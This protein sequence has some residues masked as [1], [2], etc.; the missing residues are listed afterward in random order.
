MI[1]ENNSSVRVREIDGILIILV[2]ALLHGLIYVYLVP[3]WQHYDEPNHFEY[4]WLVANRNKLPQ[5]NDYDPALTFSVLESMYANDFYKGLDYQPELGT[6]QDQRPVPGVSQL[7]G[8]PLYYGMASIPLKLILNR[9]VTTQMYFVRLISVSIL[10]LTILIAWGMVREFTPAGHP[11]RYLTPLILAML[12]GYVDVMSSINNDVGAVLFMSLSL[13]GSVRL[14][15]KGISLLNLLLAF[16]A[17]VLGFY[18]KSTAVIAFLILPVAL[19]FSLF[20]NRLRGFAWILVFSG[21]TLIILTTIT[22]DDALKWYRST[23]QS[24]PTRLATEKAVLGEY[25]IQLDASQE[26][27]PEWMNPLIQPIPIET[28]EK[29][30]GENATLGFWMWADKP[31]SMKSPVFNTGN[32]QYFELIQISDQP[33][34]FAYHTTFSDTSPRIW[35]GIDFPDSLQG[36]KNTVYVD[37][38]VLTEG[39]YPIDQPPSYAN[40]DGTT[41]SWAGKSFTNYIENGSAEIS[42]FRIIPILDGLGSDFLGDNTRPSFVLA[43]LID[44]KSTWFLYRLTIVRL[45]RTFLAKFG[46]G[47]VYIIGLHPYRNLGIFSLFLFAGIL[48]GLIRK[49]RG[50]PWEVVFLLL[51]TTAFTV[52]AV[53]VRSAIY[54]SVSHIFLPV[55]RYLYPIIIPIA[56]GMGFGWLEISGWMIR[57]TSEIIK[58]I[59]NGK[60]SIMHSFNKRKAEFQIGVLFILFIA[61][62]VYSIYSIVSFYS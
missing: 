9:D 43:S 50:I 8:K 20:R 41:G 19:I 11:L 12:P 45:F 24:E 57:I 21:F 2:I 49:R 26:T 61:F 59:N 16:G 33:E 35:I 42:G 23:S 13:W 14:V 55:G 54:I 47:H 10:L 53:L 39:L 7:A 58:K 44:I 6:A 60:V 51:I 28:G 1:A 37:G 5:I 27:S 17:A 32:F 48:F 46:W 18:T 4:V 36:D 15:T 52:L 34:F 31:A 25:V 38:I 29:V 40:V 30:I 62:D 56:I 22:R 3:P